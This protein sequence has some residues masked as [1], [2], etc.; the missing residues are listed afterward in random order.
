MLLV[1]PLPPPMGGDTRHFTTLIEDLRSS[2]CFVTTVVNTSRG[3]EHSHRIRNLLKG[4][5]VLARVVWNAARS[6]VVS[7]QSSDRGMLLFGP[8]VVAICRL[9]AKPVV[10]RVFG[11]SFGDSYEA[12]GALGRKLIRSLILSADVIL[13]QTRRLVRQLEPAASGRVEWLSTYV[14]TATEP[15]PSNAND[16]RNRGACCKFVFL[17]HLWRTKG[18]ETILDAAARLPDTCQIDLYGPCDEYS[19]D[20]ISARGR[21]RVRYCGFLTHA[22]VDSRLWDYDCLVLPTHH[23]GEGYPGVIAEAF[24][25][26]IPVIATR[27]LAIP[28]MVDEQCGVLVEPHDAVAFADAVTTMHRETQLWRRLKEGAKQRAKSFD[29]AVWSKKF[30]DICEAL[31][32]D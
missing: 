10:L 5:A 19:A 15:A 29:H 26:E 17:G 21:G 24:A 6:D 11:G 28:E 31:V 25:H 9:A 4:I 18:I 30:E 22:Q 13:L 7:F 3:V 8:F 32:V 16:R 2:G 20:D 27:W 23:P 14:K 1:G 12:Q